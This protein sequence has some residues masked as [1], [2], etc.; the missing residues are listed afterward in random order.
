MALAY[1]A[2]VPL[3]DMEFVQFHPTTLYGTNILMSEGCRGEGGYLLN[4]GGD[5]FM[6]EYAPQFMEM[7]PRDLVARSIQTE[8]DQGRGIGGKPFV[9]LDL[10]HLGEKVIS[11]RLPGIRELCV[12]F[13]GLDPVVEPIPVQPGQHY[14]MGGID[15]DHDGRTEV[16]GLY[17]AGECACVSVHGANR[18]GGN[19][20]LE[21][22][23]FGKRVG[24]AAAQDVSGEVK[25]SRSEVDGAVAAGVTRVHVRFSQRAD[26]FSEQ[27]A[28]DLRRRLTGAMDDYVQVFRHQDG[29][30][31]AVKVLRELRKLY[32]CVGVRAEGKT[33]NLDLLR[34]LEL[35]LMLD[36]ALTGAEGALAREESRGAHTRTDFPRRD[37]SGW[38]KHT[39]AYRTEEGPRLEY[40]PVVIEGLEP[41]ERS[42]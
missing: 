17:A 34:V 19:S 14:S 26:T 7:A 3:A 31:E 42:Y 27:D 4:A 28:Y 41:R 8:I 9:Y 21:T 35:D 37:D 12:H 24:E 22:I 38:L 25:F 11:E 30:R 10:R 13:A 36:V 39:L 40:R 16:E 23:V 2:G 5:R 6:S 18:L 32:A 1:R 15:A 33:F 20:L 29:L